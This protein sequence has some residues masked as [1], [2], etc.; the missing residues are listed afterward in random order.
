MNY[1]MVLQPLDPKQYK[2]SWLEC[3]QL[4]PNVKGFVTIIK[5]L[6]LVLEK[7]NCAHFSN[8]PSST[9]APSNGH[10]NFALL[11][12]LFTNTYDYCKVLTK[13]S[14]LKHNDKISFE[15]TFRYYRQ[16]QNQCL[17]EVNWSN[18]SSVIR[19]DMGIVKLQLKSIYPQS[20]RC[21][22]GQDEFWLLRCLLFLWWR[23]LW[24]WKTI[25]ESMIIKCTINKY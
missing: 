18:F 1:L 6:K 10:L 4:K 8:C 15:G 14:Q 17:K 22:D 2:R 21:S 12:C 19:I 23:F 16:K 20:R 25:K 7:N 24:A 13:R 11:F 5:L 3:N 9:I